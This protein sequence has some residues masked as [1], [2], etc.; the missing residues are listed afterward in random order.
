MAK[1]GWQG[2]GNPLIRPMEE[3]VAN[4]NNIV[5][6]HY[7]VLTIRQGED[8][9]ILA[10]HTDLKPHVLT[11]ESLLGKQE[12]DKPAQTAQTDNAESAFAQMASK[13]DEFEVLT[14]AIHP[15]HS[16][17]YNIIWGNNRNRF[18]NGTYLQRLSSLVGL[19]ASMTAQAVPLGAAA[20]TAYHDDIKA[21]QL[22]QKKMIVATGDDSLKIKE[23]IQILIKKLNKNLGWLKF[24]FGD[25]DDCQASINEFFPLNLITNKSS[26]GH[27][28]LLV[29]KGDFRKICIHTFKTGEKI[30]IKVGASDVWISTANDASSPI[31]SGYK[32]IAG[33]TVTIDPSLLGDLTKKYIM[34]TNVNLTTTCDLIFNI[35]K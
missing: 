15:L 8:A 16:L 6:Y 1:L 34:A 9:G 23:T 32:A 14:T 24:Y 21:R 4:A 33:S 25:E 2:S 13:L 17:P 31:P 29:P 3:S 22:A 5:I 27:Y 35:V 19:A 30:D 12:S 7:D 18:Y 28:Q 10:M 11:L 26:K 20:V